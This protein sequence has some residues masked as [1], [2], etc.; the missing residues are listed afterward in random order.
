M[1]DAPPTTLASLMGSGTHSRAELFA[2]VSTLVDIRR[3]PASSRPRPWPRG[4]ELTLPSLFDCGDTSITTEH[5]L[6]G[7][8]TAALLIL[9][10]GAIRH[11]E[12]R[13]TGGIDVPWISMSVA[14]SFVSALVGIAV[15]DG[16]IR[17]V[18]DPISDYI[19]VDPGSAYDGVRIRDVLR[20]SSGARWNEDYVDP[21]SDAARIAR[22]TSYP[23][24]SLDEFIAAMTPELPPGQVCRYNSADTQALGTL[25]ARATGRRLSDYM[26]ERLL[27]PLGATAPGAW[28]IDPRGREHAFAGLTLTARDYARLGEL[29][30]LDGRWEGRQVLPSSWVEES[31]LIEDDI[32]A[33]G[34]PVV[35]GEPRSLG[36][37]YQWWIDPGDRRSFSAIGVYN[38][39]IH[40]DP[41][42]R[43]VI[44]KLSANP[45]YAQ[46]DDPYP[47]PVHDAFFAA[48][49]RALE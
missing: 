27:E 33:P 26:A 40:V 2:R 10:D 35:G 38:Q 15:A 48:V 22:A 7:T 8:E 21:E 20:M 24:G 43:S 34:R 6:E 46:A 37:G 30:R 9:V 28:L 11:E 44:V 42:T 32:H 16:S 41:P 1:S 3:M 36:Y 13:R 25:V 47:G 18:D 12:Y 14:K 4:E 23:G 45:R 5:F 17:S 39:Y 31:L 19:A 29:Y 49:T